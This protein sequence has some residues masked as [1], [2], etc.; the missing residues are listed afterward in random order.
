MEPYYFAIGT[1]G[2]ANLK[3]YDENGMPMDGPKGTLTLE[4]H[5]NGVRVMGTITGLNPGMHGF[6]VHE[7]G[8]ISQGCNSAGPHYNPYMVNHGSP[9]DPLR[10]V[11]DLGNI[12]ANADG[13]ATVDIMD[14]YLTLSGVNGAIGRTIIIHEKPDDFGRSGTEDSMKTGSAGLRIA[15]GIVG[16]V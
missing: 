2:M 5:P 11:G 1:K 15:C 8:D 14:H 12:E 3:A 13:M 4:Q 10:H 7:K 9:M 16:F 6:H